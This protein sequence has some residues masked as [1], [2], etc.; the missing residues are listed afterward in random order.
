MKRNKH[1]LS[2]TR[3]CS[4]NMGALV[5]ITWFETLPGDSI[6]MSTAALVRAAP[7]VAPV[8]HPVDVRIHH[9]FV[10]NRLLW[11]DWEDFITGGPDG[12]NASQW[13]YYDNS[14]GDPVAGGL[15][16]HLGIPPGNYAPARQVS[17]LPFRAYNLI[18]NEWYRDQ[19]LQTELVVQ[20]TGGLD[21]LTTRGMQN[22]CWEKDYFTASRP[23]E[24]KGPAVTIPLGTSAPVAMYQ[25]GATNPG[26][27]GARRNDGSLNTNVQTTQTGDAGAAI[28]WQADLTGASAVTVTALREAL[29]IQRFEEARARYGSRYSEYLRYLGVRSSDARLQRPEFLGGGRQR[30]QF[31]EVLQTAPGQD[32][33]VGEL[34]GHGISAMRS[35]SWRRFFEEHG[36]VMSLMSVRPKTIYST[37]VPRGWFRKTR[38]EYWQKE[39]E[40]IGQ[41]EIKTRELWPTDALGTVFGYADRYQEYKTMMS[42]VSGE[43]RNTLNYWHLAREFAAKPALNASFVSCVPTERVFADTTSDVI[44]VQAKH[45]I[46]ARRLVS[47]GSQSFIY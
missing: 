19:D 23:W 2:H 8:M 20:K 25:A 16:D 40:G 21:T 45:S 31:S 39:Y 3:L 35:N 44:Q 26:V 47:R 37:Y 13:P 12:A 30:I 14:G 24:Q 22:I 32:S 43:F 28:S 41:A 42:S 33:E 34:K 11:D 46:H 15:A 27:V 17:A 9:W 7:L 10:P 18:W 1:N 29:A 5:P 38:E 6:Q 4:F 36:I